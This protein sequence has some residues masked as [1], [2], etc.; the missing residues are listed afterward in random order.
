LRLER[1][2]EKLCKFLQVN[3]TSNL[4]ATALSNDDSIERNARDSMLRHSMN[5]S[6]L[7]E[8]GRASL[9]DIAEN[10][11]ES[12]VARRASCSIENECNLLDQENNPLIHNLNTGNIGGNG[13]KHPGFTTLDNNTKSIKVMHGINQSVPYVQ[14]TLTNYQKSK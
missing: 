5:E 11:A 10:D 3:D 12:V 7:E 8:I 1:K 6:T 13:V 9:S 14:G 4:E 2:V